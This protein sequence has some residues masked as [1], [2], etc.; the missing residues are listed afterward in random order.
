MD[1]ARW[2]RTCT[3]AAADVLAAYPAVPHW[4]VGGH[5]LGGAMAAD[6]AGQNRGRID[7]LV[8]W[9]AYPAR[10]DDLSAVELAVLSISATSDGLATPEKIAASRALLPQTTR[11]V[12]IAGG[13]HAQFGWYGMQT[14]D[15]PAAISREEQQ[16]QVIEATL[17]VLETIAGREP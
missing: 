9:A 2:M 6:F 4:A 16:G 11:W 10:N 14:G 12:T 17:Q 1:C 5:S 13:N 7:G 8:L 3:G 15:G